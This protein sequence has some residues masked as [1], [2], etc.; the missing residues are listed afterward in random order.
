MKASGGGQLY[1]KERERDWKARRPTTQ[2]DSEGVFTL[3]IAPPSRVSKRHWAFYSPMLHVLP[4]FLFFPFSLKHFFFF[5]FP[6]DHD[7]WMKRSVR[8]KLRD[9]QE[10]IRKRGAVL[11]MPLGDTR[12]AHF[13]WCH[14]L[15]STVLMTMTMIKRNIGNKFELDSNFLRVKFISL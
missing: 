12:A 4:L 2:T 9:Q 7:K 6:C 13:R 10:G 14:H 8:M 1:A 15:L 3:I 5:Y 11:P